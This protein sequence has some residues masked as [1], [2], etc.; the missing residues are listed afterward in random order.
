[1]FDHGDLHF[2]GSTTPLAEQ[3]RFAHFV[4]SLK[5]KDWV[6]YAKRPFAGPE[7]VIRYLSAYTHRVAIG[8]HRLLGI[9]D[10]RVRF[11]YKDYADGAKK[12]TMTLTTD[13]FIRRF[14]LHILPTRFMRLRYYGFLGNRYRRDKIARCRE[15]L[16]VPTPES[17]EPESPIELLQR[18]AAIEA[19]A[20]S[21][22]LPLLGNCSCVALLPSVH[23]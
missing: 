19:T 6:V 14:L 2:S 4:A 10:N 1:M 5:S 23:G 16:G 17:R 15:L 18:L 3:T 12:K 11:L 9:D 7:Q 21:A 20:S 8:N 22:K 13:E